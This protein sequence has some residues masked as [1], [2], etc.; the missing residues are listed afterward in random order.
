LEGQHTKVFNEGQA[1]LDKLPFSQ[2]NRALVST[3]LRKIRNSNAVQGD[4]SGTAAKQIDS[5]LRAVDNPDTSLGVLAQLYTTVDGAA[6]GMGLVKDTLK[7][8]LDDRSKGQFSNIIQGYGA[9][10]EAIEA[11]EKSARLRGKF[12]GPDN[13]PVT[14]RA[15]GESGTPTALP[16]V[17][18]APLRRVMAKEDP[19]NA[20]LNTLSDQ[21]RSHEI[22]KSPG[23]T[24][25]NIGGAEGTATAGLNA[26]PFW[27]LRGTI[28]SAFGPIND[29]TSKAV[30]DALLDPQ[31]FLA[32]IDARKAKQ[33]A[34]QPW[35]AKL[36]KIIRSGGQLGA[37]VGGSAGE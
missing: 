24:S 35:E 1:L 8:T 9:T 37:R 36:E 17:D 7:R 4:A 19:T 11:A 26:G 25:I 6:P 22:Y 2:K 27:R 3:E 23:S 10:K 16:G 31:K 5:V 33:E 21:L 34:L 29:K 14:S 20:G 28:K 13:V 15:H 32:L 18:A 30:D 12:M